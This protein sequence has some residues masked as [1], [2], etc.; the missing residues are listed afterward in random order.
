MNTKQESLA[1][2]RTPA[3]E[4]D[5]FLQERYR[6]VREDL[7]PLKMST[8]P[9]LFVHLMPS[10]DEWPPTSTSAVKRLPQHG[11]V[12]FLLDVSG[13]SAGM[14]YDGRAFYLTDGDFASAVTHVF[15]NGV[16]EAVMSL[17][18]EHAPPEYKGVSLRHAEECALRFVSEAINSGLVERA[19]GFPLRVRLALIDTNTCHASPAGDSRPRASTGLAVRQTMSVLVLPEVVIRDDEQ[20]IESV[21][22]AAIERMWQ[23]WGYSGTPTY[24]EGGTGSW[25]KVR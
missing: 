6:L 3:E 14:T 7:Y 17:V 19:C 11:M 15:H 23:A 18:M 12:P 4:R 24:R 16:V 20:A 2:H 5:A 13:G 9:K 8:G 1:F 10:A 22:P 25:S 21:L